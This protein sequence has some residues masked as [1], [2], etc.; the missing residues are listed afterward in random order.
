MN[1]YITYMT[2]ITLLIICCLASIV[3]FAKRDKQPHNLDYIVKATVK[4]INKRD[5]ALYLSL[6][7]YEVMMQAFKEEAMKDTSVKKLYEVLSANKDFVLSAYPPGLLALT[8]KIGEELQ[9]RKWTI[10]LSDYYIEKKAEDPLISSYNLTMKIKANGRKYHLSMT[11]G[12]YHDSW[13]IF[14]PVKPLFVSGW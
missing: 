10:K 6:V 8:D 13:Y 3:T 14:E 1:S 11:V 4:A 9:T 7:N 12:K 5:T 2:R